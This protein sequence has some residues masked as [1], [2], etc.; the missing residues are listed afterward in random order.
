M[1]KKFNFEKKGKYFKKV[2]L[3]VELK[4]FNIKIE[5]RLFLKTMCAII[6]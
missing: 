6:F 4:F 5:L 3:N 2:C 1:N